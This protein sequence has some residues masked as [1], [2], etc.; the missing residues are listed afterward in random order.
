MLLMPTLRTVAAAAALLLTSCS[1]SPSP[2]IEN[3]RGSIRLGVVQD[4]AYYPRPLVQEFKQFNLELRPTEGRVLETA[5][6]ARVQWDITSF[7]PRCQIAIALRR[8]AHWSNY[9]WA[10]DGELA[11]MTPNWWGR[12]QEK[13][14][15]IKDP[16]F[17]SSTSHQLDVL[18][19]AKPAPSGRALTAWY[20]SGQLNPNDLGTVKAYL[21]YGCNDGNR[22]VVR[23]IE[24][25]VEPTPVGSSRPPTS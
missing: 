24:V 20:V 17:G 1:A 21:V 7:D 16:P 25:A 12:A 9:A 6:F 3:V 8:T 18:A 22:S 23:P 13:H 2:D 14:R 4:Y 10:G 19:T 11:N 15:E 5:V